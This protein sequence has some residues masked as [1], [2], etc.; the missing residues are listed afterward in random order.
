MHP[1][2][3]TSASDPGKNRGARIGVRCS[4]HDDVEVGEVQDRI[5]A[6][7]ADERRRSGEGTL[8]RLLGRDQDSRFG[9]V[10]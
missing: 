2:S 1:G 10:A 3:K 8:H 9:P 7:I 5:R 4:L 6:M